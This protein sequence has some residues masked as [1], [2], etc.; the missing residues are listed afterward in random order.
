[1]ANA[2]LT[3]LWNLVEDPKMQQWIHWNRA[4]NGFVVPN[5]AAFEAHACECRRGGRER[6]AFSPW[7]LRARIGEVAAGSATAACSGRS[8]RPAHAGP[9]YF[10]HSRYTSFLRSLSYYSF[11]KNT[12][13]D[14]VRG[15]GAESVRGDALPLARCHRPLAPS[16]PP[17]CRSST[18]TTSS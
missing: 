8:P 15:R 11:V 5:P 3:A 14:T 7:R 9:V 10:K 13:S 16:R 6:N 18:R 4:G 12:S 1:M 2:F 17:A